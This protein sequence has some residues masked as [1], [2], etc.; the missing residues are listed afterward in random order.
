[1]KVSPLLVL[2]LLSLVVFCA[3]CST[4]PP[5]RMQEGTGGVMDNKNKPAGAGD[6]QSTQLA[7]QGVGNVSE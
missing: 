7:P 1:M 3:G 4:D 2:I 5:L 6:R